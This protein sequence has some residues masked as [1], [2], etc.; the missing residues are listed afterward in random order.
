M[1]RY[2]GVLSWAFVIWKSQRDT[3]DYA[4][5][6]IS[7]NGPYTPDLGPGVGK[8]DWKIMQHAVSGLFRLVDLP[9]YIG[10]TMQSS[11]NTEVLLHWPR[12]RSGTFS[13][14]NQMEACEL[15]PIRVHPSQELGQS[16]ATR[17]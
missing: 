15:V 14:L 16:D 3:P 4:Y 5:A 7:W 2:L 9:Q 17:S 1:E 11:T 12:I 13:R 8:E 6:A 10:R